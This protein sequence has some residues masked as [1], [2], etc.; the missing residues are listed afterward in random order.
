MSGSDFFGPTGDKGN[1]YRVM[2]KIL[3]NLGF[4]Y[5]DQ[6][7]GFQ[8]DSMYDDQYNGDERGSVD[9]QVPG[10]NRYYT[11]IVD[12]NASHPIGQAYQAATGRTDFRA[13]LVRSS[14]S[15]LI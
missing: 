4:G 1:F 3:I 11:P 13:C 5:G 10:G 7:Y 12:V 2:N 14:H 9:T 8:S 6:L 15:G